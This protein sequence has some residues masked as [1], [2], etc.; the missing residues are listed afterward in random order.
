[1]I[2][3]AHRGNIDG[4]IPFLENN[5]GYLRICISQGYHVEVDVWYDGGRY[6]LGHDSPDYEIDNDF[7]VDNRVWCHAKNNVTLEKLLGIGAHCFVHETD[8]ATLTSKGFIWTY[9]GRELTGRSICVLPE[10]V[11]N[12]SM[13]EIKQSAGICSDDVKF[14]KEKI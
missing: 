7:L 1:M 4:K 11:P 13:K 2:L 9:P 10:T 5:P 12:L 3:I 6:F 14:Y 8:D